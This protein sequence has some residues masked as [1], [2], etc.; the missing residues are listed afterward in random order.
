MRPK[1][2][3][4]NLSRDVERG[5]H[6]RAKRHGGTMPKFYNNRPR[7]HK[8]ARRATWLASRASSVS[9]ARLAIVVSVR[10]DFLATLF[11]C[12]TRFLGTSSC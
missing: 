9:V 11:H 3:G 7:T 6:G 4:K 5:W 1:V 12:R 8:A 2:T 10:W